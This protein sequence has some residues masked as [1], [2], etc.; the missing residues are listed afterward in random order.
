MLAE[1][2]ALELRRLSWRR[3][4]HG[5][6]QIAGEFQKYDLLTYSSAIAF[7]VL[8]ALLPLALLG[9]AGL[10]LVGAQSVYFDHI[11]PTLQHDLS[12]EA[13]TIADRTARH[14]MN[15]KR[16]WWGTAGLAISLW[17]TGAALRSM[18]TP[19]NAIYGARETRSWFRRLWVS[20]AGGAGVAACL[21]GAIV[22]VLAGRLIHA[23]AVLGVVVALARWLIAFV[24]IL[25]SI[26]VVIRVVPAK[27]RPATWTSVGSVTSG[28][29]WVVA[30]IGFGAYISAVSYSSFY[31]ALGALV[32]ALVYV[33]VAAIAFLVGVVIDSLLRQEVSSAERGRSRRGRGRRRAGT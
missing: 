18:M 23:H 24:M 15:G 25:L 16:I 26:A 20:V 8:Y 5:I 31:G 7:Q 27:K 32:L 11:A 17:G 2:A 3:L 9:L 19:L 21:Y 29:A 10:G 33:H 12:P 4:R 13:F 28:V 1:I 14:V 30:T 22:V 6:E